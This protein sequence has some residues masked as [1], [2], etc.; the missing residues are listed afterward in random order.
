MQKIA[1][2]VGDIVEGWV[3]K[4]GVMWFD[5]GKIKDI[6]HN[7][8]IVSLIEN[9]KEQTLLPYMYKGDFRMKWCNIR[10]LFVRIKINEDYVVKKIKLY[11]GY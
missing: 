7:G 9:K 3:S 4:K 6:Y 8:L 1:F 5:K 2:K 10:A 11:G